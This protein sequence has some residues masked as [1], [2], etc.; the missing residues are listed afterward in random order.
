VWDENIDPF[1]NIVRMTVMKLRRKLG[2]P[3]IVETVAGA[4]YRI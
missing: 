2:E 1:T 3:A 4:G